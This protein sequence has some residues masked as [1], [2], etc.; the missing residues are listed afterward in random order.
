MTYGTAAATYMATKCLQLVARAVEG[1]L[2]NASRAILE[3]F[4]VDDWITG[5]DS[6]SDAIA[7]QPAV[8]KS[9]LDYG[10]PI[11]KFQSNHKE[12]LNLLDARLVEKLKEGRILGT[13]YIQ[14]LGLVWIPETDVFRVSIS[15]EPLPD[16][17][18]KRI[19][20]SDISRIFD[21]LGFL[22]PVTIRRKLISCRIF[23]E[24]T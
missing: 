22:C 4:Y 1:D 9:L 5:C 19:V 14:V 7:L 20:L 17:I 2:P 11:R 12:F 24:K 16:K 6:V 15:L 18:T 3:D 23:G 21:V 8:S 10:F 13:E